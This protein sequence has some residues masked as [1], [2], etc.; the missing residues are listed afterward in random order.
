MLGKIMKT[1][2]GIPAAPGIAYGPSYSVETGH[3][4]VERSTYDDVELE[5]L[6]MAPALAKVQTALATFSQLA[7]NGIGA[8]ESG[9]FN[10]QI[11]I[12]RDPEIHKKCSRL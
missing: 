12:L 5:L 10:A 2:T 6:K 11:E 1:I 3:L 9:I 7:R 8:R 4:H